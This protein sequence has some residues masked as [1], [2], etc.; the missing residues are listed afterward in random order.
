MLETIKILMLVLSAMLGISASFLNLKNAT[1]K[2]TVQGWLIIIGIF[3]CASISGAIQLAG[4]NDSEKKT[5]KLLEQ[6][7]LLLEN[8]SRSLSPVSPMV[9]SY[10]LRPD[11]SLKKLVQFKSIMEERNN[12]INSYGKHKTTGTSFG[13]QHLPEPSSLVNTAFLESVCTT[14]ISILFKKG[15]FEVKKYN[16]GDVYNKDDPF[17]LSLDM[18]NPCLFSIPFNKHKVNVKESETHAMMNTVYSRGKLLDINV[19]F[20]PVTF[21]GIDRGWE[22]SGKIVSILDLLGSTMIVNVNN[23]RVYATEGF[24]DS[25][26]KDLRQKTTLIELK[27][28]FQ[29]GMILSF[30]KDNMVENLDKNGQFFYSYKFPE[31]LNE[32]ISNT[33][34]D[35]MKL[36]NNTGVNFEDD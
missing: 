24:T 14:D 18:R 1:G 20:S 9:I 31:T 13:S 28:K 35:T 19:E 36:I 26:L 3:V 2:V 34:Y 25:E 30:D 32:L 12:K 29:N 15:S 17:D 4:D 22:G 5:I 10:N 21:T 27:F 16:Y 33:K 23:F 6:N 8:A 11:L 7:N